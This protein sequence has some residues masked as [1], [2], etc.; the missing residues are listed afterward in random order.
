M[1]YS[2]GRSVYGLAGIGS[3]IC[4]LAWHD[5]SNWQQVKALG[6]VPHREILTYIVATIEILGG[7]A[8]QWPRT[9]RAGAV[10]LG[11]IYFTFSLFAVP[12]IIQHPLVYIPFSNFFAQSSL[13]SRTPTL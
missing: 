11:T 7:V 12:L 6:D 8:V 9:A 10:A 13:P 2:L 5:F 3:G 4:A 1:K